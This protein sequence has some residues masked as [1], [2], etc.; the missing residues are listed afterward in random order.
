MSTPV[1]PRAAFTQGCRYD[2]TDPELLAAAIEA[3]FDYRGDVT[4]T[5]D[6][7][8]PLT[9]YLSNRNL[10]CS[11]SFIEIFLSN[12][13]RPRRIPFAKLRGVAIT[14]KDTA[15]GK[16]WETWLRKYRDKLEAEARGE[17]VGSIG[18]FP[19]SLE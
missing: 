5:V 17:K 15:S 11:D 12:D 7:V 3:A 1:D 19:E 14:G 8:G 10:E 4:I 2:G 16:S 6:G 9:G 13:S 18:L